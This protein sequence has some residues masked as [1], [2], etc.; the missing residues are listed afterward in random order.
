[1]NFTPSFSTASVRP[2]MQTRHALTSRT[3]GRRPLGGF[4]SSPPRCECL[5]GFRWAF[6]G[7]VWVIFG[8]PGGFGVPLR[9]RAGLEGLGQTARNFRTSLTL[10]GANSFLRF[11]AGDTACSPKLKNTHTHTP[12]KGFNGHG[13]GNVALEV[14]SR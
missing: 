9:I 5:L 14:V 12:A 13:L 1:M 11:A 2:S 7:E 10:R 3:K 4:L 8:D 6:A